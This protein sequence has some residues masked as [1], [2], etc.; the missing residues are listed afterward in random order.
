MNSTAQ[1]AIPPL[2]QGPQIL[3][4]EADRGRARREHL[5][6]RAFE[7][8]GAKAN[9]WFLPCDFADGGTWAGVKD[10][11]G[12][13]MPR[14]REIAPALVVKHD[15]ELAAILPGQRRSIPVRNPSLTDLADNDEKVRNF[16]VDRAYRLVHGL[17]N[18]LV[19][20]HATGAAGSSLTL[21]CDAYDRG[22]ALLRRFF[23]ELVRR[24]GRAL[25]LKLVLVVDPG[26][27][28][29]VAA[30]FDPSWPLE[31]ARLD[32]TPIPEEVLSPEEA[33]GRLRELSQRVRGDI[34][35]V[36][37]C[38]QDL[39]RLSQQSGQPEET[40]KWQALG[41]G[42]CNHYG[43]YE[44][45][46]IYGRAVLPQLEEISRGSDETRWNLVGNLFNAAALTGDPD[47]AYRIIEKEAAE[48]ITDP[49]VRIRVYYILAM[50]YTRYL[51][52]EKR[53]MARAEKYLQDGLDGLAA[54]DL[55]PDQ[56]YF[57]KVFIMNG[58]ALLRHRQ[59]RAIEAVE[60]CRSGLSLLE[61]HLEPTRHRLHRS[62]LFYN[63]AQVYAAIG[64]SAEAVENFSAAMAMDP[65]Y[66][67]YYNDRGSAFLKLGRYQEAEADYRMAIELSPPYPEVLTNLGQCYRLM[68]R[69][70]DAIA[71]YSAAI[72]LDPKDVMPV[73]G[74]AQ[75]HDALGQLKEAL[76]DY[77]T[78]IA[79]TPNRE[80]VLANRAVLYYQLGRLDE[81]I[82]DLDHAI[83]IS[84]DTAEFY[85]NR[86]VALGDIGRRESA[87]RDLLMYLKLA[88]EAEDRAD[89]EEKLAALRAES[90][91]GPVAVSP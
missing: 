89:V 9:A 53:D 46:R 8:G 48:K 30:E 24:R 12:A 66:S 11:F 45:A 67:E 74:R 72:D 73:E 7:L 70:E 47:E 2:S 55:P 27:G 40:L 61:Q 44:D 13:L 33:A 69:M 41:L 58:L 31:R 75:A 68:D 37:S 71:A 81:S 79:L 6:Q 87:I 49:R 18:L 65:N 23:R 84:P 57:Q 16:A 76:A 28:D 25:N 80:T 91:A 50:L 85:Q 26:K 52:P 3:V 5:Q 15:Y 90:A 88:P 63:M 19:A 62:V 1:L 35:A 14:F 42:I 39:I 36:E 86:A 34:A 38:L 21:V 64:A 82:A 56:K 29:A 43:F 20:W 78:I 77:D 17:I 51:S 59:G 60:L 22:G 54:L 4:V 83:S 10:L 32:L